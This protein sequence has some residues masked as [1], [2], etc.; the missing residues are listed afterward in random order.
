MD[1]KG[2]GESSTAEYVR[3]E[4]CA[5][6]RSNSEEDDCAKN[7]VWSIPDFLYGVNEKQSI[8]DQN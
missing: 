1:P 2:R 4:I 7:A 3:Q 6:V 8:N 5:Q